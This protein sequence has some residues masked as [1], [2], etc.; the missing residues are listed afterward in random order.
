MTLSGIYRTE[1]GHEEEEKGEVEEEEEE[2]LRNWVN[3]VGRPGLVHPTDLW[4]VIAVCGR[5]FCCL[6]DPRSAAWCQWASHS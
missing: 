5:P 3:K 2:D 1:G 6:L 4:F